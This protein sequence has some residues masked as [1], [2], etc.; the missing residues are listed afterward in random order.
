METDP[1]LRTQ[2]SANRRE[3]GAQDELEPLD[4]YDNSVEK[5]IAVKRKYI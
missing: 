5:N 4:G 3:E 1:P 2:N